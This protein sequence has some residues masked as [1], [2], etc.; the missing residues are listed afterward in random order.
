LTRRIR[1]VKHSS[2]FI[3][4]AFRRIPQVL[5]LA[6]NPIGRQNS[7]VKVSLTKEQDAW[8]KA[9]YRAGGYASTS[10]IVREAIRLLQQLEIDQILPSGIEDELLRRLKKATL[11]PM[12]K[13]FFA[14]LRRKQHA[15]LH[16]ARPKRA[17]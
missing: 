12:P 14:T 1:Q 9:R 6:N 4:S 10:E 11:K 2:D 7:V 3:H 16:A 13:N 17:A 15:R 5:S 8:L